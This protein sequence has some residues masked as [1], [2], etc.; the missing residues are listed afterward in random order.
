MDDDDIFG[1]D[2][3]I[4]PSDSNSEEEDKE[5]LLSF[6]DD[7]EN[8]QPEE[9]K[10]QRFANVNAEKIDFNEF[11]ELSKSSDFPSNVINLIDQY[12]EQYL[13]CVNNG[14]ILSTE[15]LEEF[16][17]NLLLCCKRAENSIKFT[18]IKKSIFEFEFELRLATFYLISFIS[19]K[20]PSDSSCFLQILDRF[21][22]E[23]KNH[24]D[25]YYLQKR[26]Y[27]LFS[28]Y[29][30]IIKFNSFDSIADAISWLSIDENHSFENELFAP[31][32]CLADGIKCFAHHLYQ[33]AVQR[34]EKAFNLF[35]KKCIEMK[36]NCLILYYFSSFYL[37]NEIKI[38]PSSN[39]KYFEDLILFRQGLDLISN[40]NEVKKII[41]GNKTEID[42]DDYKFYF[43]DEN[44]LIALQ[45]VK[46][47]IQ[48]DY[49]LAALKTDEMCKKIG[50]NYSF[51]SHISSKIF[52]V[53]IKKKSIIHFIKSY[54][55]IQVDFIR[56][57]FSFDSIE[58]AR[59]ILIDMIRKKEICHFLNDENDILEIDKKKKKKENEY[60]EFNELQTSMGC[61]THLM[62]IINNN[63]SFC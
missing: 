24:P 2:G 27:V 41:E 38:V 7:E 5:P 16:N 53:I 49:Q 4:I 58:E 22:D 36:K 55:R 56:R 40:P 1:Q 48:A 9:P 32:V 42:D 12:L 8:L 35:P 29:L 19:T 52:S 28:T 10:F 60:D 13:N 3:Q 18:D 6:S 62:T 14:S 43:K 39:Q 20:N 61:L 26:Y 11:N 34:T 33:Q 59:T 15:S 46:Y 21:D 44:L 17:K 30:I 51:V 37:T 57:R 47:H 31:Y 54:R 23:D 50:E 45:F 25:F 63:K